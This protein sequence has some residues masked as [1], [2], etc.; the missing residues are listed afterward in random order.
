MEVLCLKVLFVTA[1][2]SD[3]KLLPSLHLHH[4]KYD[5]WICYV[6]SVS[7]L[8]LAAGSLQLREVGNH[9]LSAFL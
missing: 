8:V 2:L 9:S 6:T 7:V 3:G 5:I 1:N 4:M